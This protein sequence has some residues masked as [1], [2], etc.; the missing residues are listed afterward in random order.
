MAA[1]MAS[2]L[3]MLAGGLAI[4]AGAELATAAIPGGIQSS[5]SFPGQDV[6]IGGP[7]PDVHLHRHR[8]RRRRALTQGDRDDIAFV[9]GMISAAAAKDFVVAL[10]GR[11]R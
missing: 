7:H 6:F 11:A 4:G 5:F 1:W 9:K 3:R 2:A 10:A 8:R